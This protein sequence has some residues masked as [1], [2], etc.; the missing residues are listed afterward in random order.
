MKAG[1]DDKGVL[2]IEAESNVEQ[3]ALTAWI[4]E[5]INE[6]DGI[7]KIKNEEFAIMNK[8]RTERLV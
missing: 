4:E 3:Y 2:F 5:N 1:F 8:G 7:V 6:F